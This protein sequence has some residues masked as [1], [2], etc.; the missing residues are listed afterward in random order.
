MGWILCRASVSVVGLSASAGHSSGVAPFPGVED[1]SLPG[2]S[3]GRSVIFKRRRILAGWRE[4]P[5]PGALASGTRRDGPGGAAA[6][7][8]AP[9]GQA[10]ST[11]PLCHRTRAR[12]GDSFP[13][14]PA[15][16]FMF[17]EPQ[18][19]RRKLGAPCPLRGATRTPRRVPRPGV[20]LALRTACSPRSHG[21][22]PRQAPVL[23]SQGLATQR[24]TRR[25]M[26]A[27]R[28]PGRRPGG[29]PGAGAGASA[30]LAQRIPSPR[31]LPAPRGPLLAR[32]GGGARG[33][34]AARGG[35]P[36]RGRELGPKTRGGDAWGPG[37]PLV[38]T[39]RAGVPQPSR[40]RRSPRWSCR[41]PPRKPR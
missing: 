28:A 1:D 4:E 36:G 5:A 32:W 37:L 9:P 11:G 26:R 23:P 25:G 35:V 19:G 17:S 3:R 31:R 41:G 8:T 12:P 30:V 2:R 16:T 34:Q 22:G 7:A 38:L 29:R 33:A 27:P 39:C 10:G 15:Q 21:P 14:Q 24:G 20:Q 18:G 6:G 40:A 13:H